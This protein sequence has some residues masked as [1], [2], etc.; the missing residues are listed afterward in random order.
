MHDLY[1]GCDALSIGL[2]LGANMVDV[3]LL[4]EGS[5]VG[6]PQ[7]T[8]DALQPTLGEHCKVSASTCTLRSF[9]KAAMLT[10]KL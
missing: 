2:C 7:A 9:G 4:M 8:D 10:K 6:R 5:G 1:S 3:N